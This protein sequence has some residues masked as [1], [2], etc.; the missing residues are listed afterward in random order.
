WPL[1]A[2]AVALMIAG[3]VLSLGPDGV[4][5]L[6]AFLQQ[7]VYGFQAI[8]A[9]ARFAVMVVF[10]LAV[11]AAVGARGV[12]RLGSR[13]DARAG[14]L[15]PVAIVLLVLIEYANRPLAL[16]D[17]PP[18]STPAGQWLSQSRTPGAV[19]YLPLTIDIE[20]TPFM[21]ESLE[22]GRPIVNG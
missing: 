5:P 11:L 20:N 22:H 1:A 8:R 10:G 13:L 15:V 7:W 16:V 17:A 19:L 14:Q 4:R 3:V 9:P 18:L 6:Y 21:V 2:E 12:Q